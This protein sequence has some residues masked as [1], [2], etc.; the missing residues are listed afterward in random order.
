M[1]EFLIEV[2][3]FVYSKIEATGVPSK[4]QVEFATKIGKRLA[5]NLGANIDIVEVGTLLMDSMLGEA[6]KQSRGEEHAKMA[7]KE[8]DNLLV[9]S[10]LSEEEKENIRQCVLE[11]HGV[12]KFY[13]LESEICC[14]ADCYKFTSIKGFLISLRYTKERPFRE[15]VNLLTE[16]LN[17]K[18]NALSLNV[19]K[20]ELTPQ[21]K[22]IVGLLEELSEE[23]L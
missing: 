18:W 7:L 6:Y 14:N 5:K 10:S 16:K 12:S 2:R 19:C 11:H 9:Q 3:K 15:L 8:T 21:H 1:E 20:N 23:E 13:S 17:E 4:P 22:I